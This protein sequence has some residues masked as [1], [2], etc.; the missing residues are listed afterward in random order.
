M[1][2][3]AATFGILATLFLAAAFSAPAAGTAE[4]AGGSFAAQKKIRIVADGSPFGPM[5]YNRQRQ[6]I[7]VFDRDARKRSRCYGGCARAWPPVLTRGRP[8]A[9]PGVRQK[10]LGTFR[11]RG[12]ATQVTYRGRPLY[13]Y[14]H[15]GP[16]QVLC[17]NIFLNGGLWKVVRPNGRL[18]K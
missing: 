6:A 7:Y 8:K 12:G 15:E 14:A 18:A 3:R 9:G 13:Y 5:I 16:N 4:R 1:N 2:L 10:L 17:H 11:R